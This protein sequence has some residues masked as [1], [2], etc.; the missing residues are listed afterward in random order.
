METLVNE[1]VAFFRLGGLLKKL[2]ADDF[3]WLLT[4]EGLAAVLAP[5]LSLVLLFEVG[6]AL[7]RR[8]YQHKHFVPQFLTYLLNR[9]IVSFVFIGSIAFWV[10]VFEPIRP[11]TVPFTWWGFVYGFLV[12]ELAVWVLHWASH[13]VRLL[14]CVH[15]THHTSETMNIGVASSNFILEQAYLALFKALICTV[16]GVAPAVLLAVLLID[17]VWVRFAHISEET[18]PNGRLGFLNRFL[19]TPSRHRVHHARNPLYLDQNFS[20]TLNFWDWAFGTLQREERHEKIEYGITRPVNHANFLDFYMG[21]WFALWRDVRHAPGWRNKLRYLVMPPGWSHA[22][23]SKLA[24]P[25]R[26]AYLNGLPQRRPD[27][28]PVQPVATP[29]DGP[30]F[31]KNQTQFP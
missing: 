12:F 10:G 13:K 16:F 24:G 8:R 31:R 25:T 18:L 3:S 5:T 19:I 6:A 30:F 29:S 22:G 1:L 11:F 28:H 17:G 7:V 15:A 21:E 4:P 27:A 14:W 20:N 23:D 9:L 2:Q 26:R